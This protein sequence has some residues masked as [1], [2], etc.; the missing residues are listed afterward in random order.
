M[1][2]ASRPARPARSRACRRFWRRL[3]IPGRY[4]EWSRP[5][6]EEGVVRK[7]RSR[8]SRSGSGSRNYGPAYVRCDARSSRTVKPRSPG[9][10]HLVAWSIRRAAASTRT[11]RRVSFPHRPG[12]AAVANRE[13]GRDAAGEGARP[14]LSAGR[15]EAGRRAVPDGRLHRAA[16]ASCSPCVSATSTSRPRRSHV[17][18]RSGWACRRA[19]APSSA[20]RPSPS[21][22]PSAACC[23]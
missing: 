7:R 14:R 17:R 16:S 2:T 23:A 4:G 3:S 9:D 1:A 5:A 8:R 18:C 12:S 15:A 13:D 10:A 21:S 19:A 22:C 20:T 11:T 6:P